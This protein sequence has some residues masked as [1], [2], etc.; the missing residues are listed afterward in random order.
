MPVKMAANEYPRGMWRTVGGGGGAN[1]PGKAGHSH[2]TG[3][4]LSRYRSYSSPKVGP[5]TM[6]TPLVLIYEARGGPTPKV[7][8]GKLPGAVAIPSIHRKSKP[9]LTHRFGRR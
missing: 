1:R 2:P 5:N 3:S 9:A 4:D 8:L 6:L 7:P